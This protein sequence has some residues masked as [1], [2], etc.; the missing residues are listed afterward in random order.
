MKRVRHEGF[1]PSTYSLSG[2][3]STT[4]LMARYFLSPK[5]YPRQDLK[6]TNKP[7]NEN[8]DGYNVSGATAESNRKPF[9]V[10][11]LVTRL[12]VANS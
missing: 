2:S 8:P 7:G 9:I 5:K 3:C 10:S 6:G 11:L 4:E 1:E 12:K